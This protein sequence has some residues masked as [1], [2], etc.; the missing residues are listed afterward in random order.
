MASYKKDDSCAKAAPPRHAP[1]PRGAGVRNTSSI[2]AL[3]AV[4][5]VCLQPF[6]LACYL[7]ADACLK[8]VISVRLGVRRPGFQQRVSRQ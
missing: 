2:K 1:S 7:L 4:M 6:T 3:I 8:V 5:N